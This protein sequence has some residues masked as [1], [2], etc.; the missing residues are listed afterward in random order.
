MGIPSI[1]NRFVPLPK[2]RATRRSCT[3][4]R[5]HAAHRNL[6]EVDRDDVEDAHEADLDDRFGFALF[7]GT[8]SDDDFG[9][10]RFAIFLALNDV[11]SEDDVFEIEDREV[12]IFQFFGGVE[13]YDVVQRTNQF[14]NSGN[15]KPW[16]TINS[17]GVP[18]NAG[19]VRPGRLF[20]GTF[21]IDS[22]SGFA[23]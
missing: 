19:Q 7:K 13:G 21:P 11:A 17:T 6:D 1:T 3:P 10:A 2:V 5:P 9:F 23:Q 12:V 20:L 16:H 4:A 15:R 22:Q 18:L 8:P 14:A